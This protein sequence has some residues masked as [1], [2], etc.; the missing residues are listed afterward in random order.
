MNLTLIQM[1]LAQVFTIGLALSM[2]TTVAGINILVLLLLL[3]GAW[4]WS[5]FEVDVDDRKE[6]RIFFCLIIALCIVDVISNLVA[7][8]S[9]LATLKLLIGD[10][11]TFFFVIVLWPLFAE[12]KISRLMFWGL[13]VVVS[14]ISAADLISV[15]M[16]G[17]KYLFPGS[18]P[19]MNA[20]IL[21][22]IC[23]VLA[24]ILLYSPRL[25][26]RLL[27]PMSVMLAGLFLAS[28]RRTGW[29]LLLFGIGFW[30]YLNRKILISRRYAKWMAIAFI[31]IV[32]LMLSSKFVQQR[33]SLAADEALVFLS[34][35]REDRINKP[36]SIG[37]RM[38]YAV[39]SIELIQESGFWGV[40]SI[41]FRD[42][43][44][45]VNGSVDGLQSQYSNP[46]NEY[47]YMLMT[48][49]WVGLIIYLAIFIQA[50]RMALRKSDPVQR[51]GMLMMVLLFMLSININSM[52][53]DMR[54]GHFTMLMILVF[55]APKHLNLAKAIECNIA[56]K[57][58]A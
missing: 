10:L 56:K 48:K 38:Q 47:L 32:S 22:G 4:S 23:F 6:V 21:V 15:A 58:M 44:W 20:Q 13:V 19:N 24:Q 41:N 29:F 31:C 54:E 30:I 7:G 52:M 27:L 55:L 26:G 49:G 2:L 40:G 34:Q 14:L 9:L 39:S 35:T 45:R 1:K 3:L 43:F 51:I 37:V 18:G 8:H 46:H 5:T 50:C 25:G 28:E 33:V 42:A 16:G 12:V 17:P 53:I 11:R 36:T 57:L